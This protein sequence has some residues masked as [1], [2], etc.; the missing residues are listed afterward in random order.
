MKKAM[1]LAAG[2]G[3]RM[4]ELTTNL[5]KPLLRVGGRYL[6]EYAISNIKH[7]GIHEIV[8]N[9]SWQGDQIKTALG[10]G[11]QYGVKIIYSEEAERLETG[12]GIFQAL[13]LLGDQ[14]FLVVSSDIITDYPLR[15]L[16]QH[17]ESLAHLVMV[18]NPDYHSEGDYGLKDGRVE[19]DARQKLTYGNVGVYRAELFANCLPGHFRLSSVLNPAIAAGKVT[20]EHYQGKW[21]NV[22]TPADL[23]EVS[24]LIV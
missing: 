5:P 15:E 21:H 14:P 9:V 20:G 18:G 3:Q 4:G 17:P 23:E 7:A 13:S 12:G 22:G 8:I 1:I 11:S 16:P 24:S 19:L 2:R 6:I 10:D